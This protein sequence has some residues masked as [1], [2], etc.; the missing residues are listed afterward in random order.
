MLNFPVCVLVILTEKIIYPPLSL[1]LRNPHRHLTIIL[2]G[3]IIGGIV[4]SWSSVVAFIASV[5]TST[6]S[7]RSLSHTGLC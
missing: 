5:P 1:S 2:L 7:A 4:S 3:F 6:S